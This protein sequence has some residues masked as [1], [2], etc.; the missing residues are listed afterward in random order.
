MGQTFNDI[1]TGS[2]LVVAGLVAG[3]VLF[4]ALTVLGI[5]L[6]IIGILVSGLFFVL[7]IL[8]CV[9]FVGFI[10]RKAR[11]RKRE[12]IDAACPGKRDRDSSG[13]RP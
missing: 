3:V 9:W 7:L 13:R 4:A 8:F 2:V 11:E 10:F 6:H 12:V 1:V 5:L